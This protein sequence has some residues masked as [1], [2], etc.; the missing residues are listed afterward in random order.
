MLMNS[1]RFPSMTLRS[2]TM[3]QASNT[4][5][6]YALSFSSSTGNTRTSV[7]CMT[8]LPL[9][10]FTGSAGRGNGAAALDARALGQPQAGEPFAQRARAAAIRQPEGGAA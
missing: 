9:G 7:I 5:E 4:I 6:A 3:K 2:L 8:L 10:T 1:P